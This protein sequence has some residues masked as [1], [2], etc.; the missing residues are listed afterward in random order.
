MPSPS[1]HHARTIDLSAK[2]WGRDYT[3]TPI[4]GGVKGSVMGWSTPLPREGDYLILRDGPDRTTRY[5]VKS[6]KA[7]HDPPDMFAADVEFAP[8]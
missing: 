1:S 4:D 7:M 5:R 6:V 2:S 3:F 8:R